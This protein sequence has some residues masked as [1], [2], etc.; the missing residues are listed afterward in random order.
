MDPCRRRSPRL[1]RLRRVTAALSC[2]LPSL[3][4]MPVIVMRLVLVLLPAAS[5]LLRGPASPRLAR[6][7]QPAPFRVALRLTEPTPP[8]AALDANRLDDAPL[9]ST[10]EPP[11]PS[12]EW[13][14]L[15]LNAGL[16]VSLHAFF[17]T[18]AA[19]VSG[20]PDGGTA[21]STAVGRGLGLAAFVALQQ[22]RGLP[23]AVWLG[24]LGQ[25]GKQ[26][27]VPS[28]LASP[29]APLGAVVLFLL[30]TRTLT[31]DPNPRP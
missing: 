22:T 11:P 24:Q 10:E 29:L 5:C 9:L 8:K 20:A 16:F 17:L 27:P 14:D 30:L 15:A 18:G 6:A 28:A 12:M 26:P 1:R 7:G 21:A 19:L 13:S 31:L 23:T 2:S 3:A 4:R 25:D